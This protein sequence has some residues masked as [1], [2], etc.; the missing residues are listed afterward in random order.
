MNR[1]FQLLGLLLIGLLSFQAETARAAPSDNCYD[2]PD[3]VICTDEECQYEICWYGV[4]MI[5]DDE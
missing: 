5:C 1:T 2:M 3:C 4:A